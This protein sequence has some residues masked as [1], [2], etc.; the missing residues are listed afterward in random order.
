MASG[1]GSRPSYEY[2]PGAARSHQADSQ[3]SA[4]QA[5]RLASAP[6]RRPA[7]PPRAGWLAGALLLLDSCA[8]IIMPSQSPQHRQNQSSPAA[9]AFDQIHSLFLVPTCGRF[10]CS[11]QA[12]FCC[13]FLHYHRHFRLPD[14]TG[15]MVALPTNHA[16]RILQ[17]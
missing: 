4:A 12:V 13:S 8:V 16:H 14:E 1:S 2:E 15:S 5:R 9:H 17:Q 7:G 3:N 10:S 6:A 11:P